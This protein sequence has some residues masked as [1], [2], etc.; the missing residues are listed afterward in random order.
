MK[1]DRWENQNVTTTR[2]GGSQISREEHIDRTRSAPTTT[3]TP[4]WWDRPLESATAEV[5]YEGLAQR[6]QSGYPQ[7]GHETLPTPTQQLFPSLPNLAPST[8]HPI[9]PLHPQISQS[10]ADRYQLPPPVS[11]LPYQPPSKEWNQALPPSYTGWEQPPVQQPQT[12]PSQSRHQESFSSTNTPP[13][14]AAVRL[15]SL[16]CSFDSKLTLNTT[17]D[18]LRNLC[19]FAIDRPISSIQFDLYRFRVRE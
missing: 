12:L 10:L 16:L 3:H 6:Y 9:L 18:D 15:R 5:P 2:E 11:Q 4:Q 7:T 14:L 1:R 13:L 19:Y 17:G 8:H